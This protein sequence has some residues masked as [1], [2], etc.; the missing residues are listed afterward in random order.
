M[1]TNFYLNNGLALV[2]LLTATIL[3]L[4][5][6]EKISIH[7]RMALLGVSL[8]LTMCVYTLGHIGVF[9]FNNVYLGILSFFC[10]G[11]A[12][13]FLSFLV[14][15]TGTTRSRRFKSLYALPFFLAPLCVFVNRPAGLFLIS[16]TGLILLV[17]YSFYI[18]IVWI[19]SATDAP[20][21]R[22]GQWILSLCLI[23]TIGAIICAINNLTGLFWV[24]TIWFLWTY[25]AVNHLKIFQQL[26]HL[27]NKL[28]IDNVFDVIL[29]LDAKGHV[30]RMNRR[31]CQLTGVSSLAVIGSG[32]EELVIH[33]ELNKES[34]VEWLRKNG[35]H[36]TGSGLG[37]TPSFDSFL[38]RNNGEKISVDLR[39]ICLVDL[40][41]KTTGYILSAT[42]MRITHQLMS[43]VSDREYAAR[44]LALSESKFSR[45]FIFNPTGILIVNLESLK[46]T[47]ANPAIEEIFECETK[48]LTGKTLTEIGLEME[49]IP[50][51]VFIEKIIME[52]SV[53]E[54]GATLKLSPDKVRKCR[55]SAV[56]F[57]LN[58]T[59]SILLSVS[60]VT[61]HEKMCEAL[62]RKEKV[63]TIGI[64]A[65]G[66]AHD[67]NNILAVILG[68]IGLAKM[69]TVDQHARAPIEKAE[70]A[71]LRA[72]EI[73]GQLL[74]FSRGGKP[75]FALCDTR[76]LITDTAMIAVNDTAVACLFDIEKD[77]WQLKADK[78]QIGQ[79]ISNLVRNA[80]QAMNKSGIIEIQAKNWN[81]KNTSAKKRPLT[82]DSKPLNAS[83]YVEI[84]IHDQ[85]PGIPDSVRAKMFDPFFTTKETGTG[86]G[87]AIV[88]SVIQ[89][90]FGS[91]RVETASGEGTTFILFLPAEPI[92]I[93]EPGEI[94]KDM[95]SNELCLSKKI[96]VL[97]MD[98]NPS[99]RET[100]SNLLCTF[101][102][103]VI[104]TC[105]GEEAAVRYRDVIESGKTI[106]FCILDLLVPGGMSGIDC[107]K[108]ILAINPDAVLLVS[109][110]YS[111][112]PVLAH[113]QDFGFK[114][115]IP[116]PYTLE[117]LH[118]VLSNMLVL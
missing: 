105:D 82:I 81:F 34:R 68:H 17:A 53:S 54:F 46:I 12:V 100:A 32:V 9:Q 3:N 47:D 62:T 39:I 87:L 1:Y 7:Y 110:G 101:G 23:F 64:L 104:E 29:I 113:Y 80:V 31:G 86:L 74:A 20:A 84:R 35:W 45:M 96:T 33:P 63:E 92:V 75:V 56:S 78:I 65:G 22:D 11:T 59:G 115:I 107:A 99:V 60:D 28:V 108:K 106:D 114:G 71:C 72:R 40:Q 111:D 90:H 102:F 103:D 44:E 16:L 13:L 97:V 93:D 55:L 42:D 38:L 117:E 5:N 61:Q 24:L 2:I 37:R 67:F 116:K 52:G 69:R 41:N 25:I 57:N 19:H 48:T 14:D 112:D 118:Q 70:D 8:A 85:G 83:S 50:F 36:D 51:D 88:F 26:T 79:V 30:V 49:E 66:I 15:F 89:N 43:E 58:Q 76:Q 95:R 4:V 21:R 94:K 18:M 27:E 109:S 73:T 91:I 10:W 98:D 77:I 6:K